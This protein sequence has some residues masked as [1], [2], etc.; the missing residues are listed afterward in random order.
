MFI[1]QIH[2]HSM[3]PTIPDGSY[4]L[5]NTEVVG[6]RSNK[7][8]LVKKEGYVDSETQ[9]SFTIKRYFSKKI[10]NSENDWQHTEIKLKPDNKD[11]PILTIEADEAENFTVIARFIEVL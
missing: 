11:Y 1:S 6:D 5:F 10:V 9:A 7:V 4:C 3:E 8:L 2:G